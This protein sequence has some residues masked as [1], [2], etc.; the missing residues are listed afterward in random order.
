MK[1]ALPGATLSLLFQLAEATADPDIDAA[2]LKWKYLKGNKWQPLLPKFQLLD[3]ATDGLIASGIVRF[4]MPFEW[5]SAGTT[6]LPPGLFWLKVEAAEH[7]AAVSDAILVQAGAVKTA[8]SP[9]AENDLARLSGPLAAASVNRLDVKDAAVK[10]VE[11]PFESF[12]GQPPEDPTQFYRRAGERL[13]HKGRAIALYDYERLVLEAFPEIFQAKCLTHTDALPSGSDHHIAP[14]HVALAVIPDMT[15]FGFE[16]R[17]QPKASRALLH[18]IEAFLQV[19]RSPFIHFKAVNP[20]Y[21]PVRVTATVVFREGFDQDLYKEKL[22]DDL[23][24]FLAPWAFGEQERLA[25]GG[26]LFRS[27]VLLF[28]EKREYVD[29]VTAFGLFKPL[30]PTPDENLAVAEVSQ[31]R[32]ILVLPRPE[33]GDIESL[34]HKEAAE[35]LTPLSEENKYGAGSVGFLNFETGDCS[36]N[37]PN[38]DEPAKQPDATPENGSTIN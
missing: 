31:A 27:E 13:R 33:E 17:L 2:D 15:R 3:D 7:T 20:I 19:R 34:T 5:S 14:G 28:V 26:K 29:F 37:E 9:T 23:L 4:S 21:E 1:N 16:A 6:I 11:Q 36:V 18:R 32:S 22:A 25:F 8:F 35:L 12:G 24:A 30:S 38:C 10:K